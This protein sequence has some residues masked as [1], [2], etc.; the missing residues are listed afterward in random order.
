MKYIVTRTS[1]WGE[2]DPKLN[3]VQK[4]M[5]SFSYPSGIKDKSEELR[6]VYT[7]EINSLEALHQLMKD[8]KHP[9]VL[10]NPSK[11]GFQ[12]PQIEIYDDYRE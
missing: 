12:L 5:L 1:N 10:S 6:E 11:D 3:G 4:E 2:D 9:V 8:C 7:I